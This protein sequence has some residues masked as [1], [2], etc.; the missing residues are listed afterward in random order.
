M[1]DLW[2]K[3]EVDGDFKSSSRILEPDHFQC[4]FLI[5][6][7]VFSLWLIALLLDIITNPSFGLIELMLAGLFACLLVTAVNFFLFSTSLWSAITHDT[8]ERRYFDSI[9]GREMIATPARTISTE[10]YEYSMEI[11]VKNK[12]V[13]FAIL[14]Y[15]AVTSFIFIFIAMI[16]K[17]G[18]T[19]NLLKTD[20]LLLNYLGESYYNCT[21]EIRAEK[22]GK[23]KETS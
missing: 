13:A 18:K 14:G 7:V 23:K 16:R 9:L 1:E 22:N 8:L 5:M 20:I 11:L 21:G 3:G 12:T 19:Q 6:G 4:M 15:G 2:S 10:E 17:L